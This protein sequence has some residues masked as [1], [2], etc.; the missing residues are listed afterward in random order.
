MPAGATYKVSGAERRSADGSAASNLQ[1]RAADLKF[2][3]PRYTAFPKC[4]LLLTHPI[5]CANTNR[6]V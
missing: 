5:S 2:A 6:V 4:A 3:G 1:E